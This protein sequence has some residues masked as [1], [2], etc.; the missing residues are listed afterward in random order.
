[1]SFNFM[2]I[3]PSGGPPIVSMATYGITFNN[4]VIELM[5]RPDEIKIGFDEEKKVIGVKPVYEPN[6][7]SP[8]FPFAKRERQGTVRIGQK[9]FIKYITNRTSIDFSTSK[10][11]FGNW[12]ENEQ[13]LTI[14]LT[15]PIDDVPSKQI[16]D[17]EAF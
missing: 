17:D 4:S 14:D 3:T 7:D 15:K 2:W 13:L 9:D 10:K 6:N 1:M 8:G 5:K 11:Y 16:E 12:D